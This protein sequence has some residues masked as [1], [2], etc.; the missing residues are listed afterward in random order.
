ML[1]PEGWRGVLA[2]ADKLDAQAVLQ[3]SQGGWSSMLREVI[4]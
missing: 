2:L 3:A 4:C 1:P